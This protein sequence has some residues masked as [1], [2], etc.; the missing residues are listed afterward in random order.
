ML[1]LP[2]LKVPPRDV[3]R[4]TNVEPKPYI[5]VSRQ[6][7]IVHGRVQLVALFQAAQKD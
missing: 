7:E 2:Q 3:P 6:T 5:L 1:S 4:P